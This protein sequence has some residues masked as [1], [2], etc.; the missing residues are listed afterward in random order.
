[1]SVGARILPVATALLLS[2]GLAGRCCAADTHS[3]SPPSGLVRLAAAKFPNLTRCERAIL[4]SA[5]LNTTAHG[6]P[7]PCG[8]SPQFDDPTNDPKNAAQWDRQRDVRAELIRWLFVDPEAVRQVDPRGVAALGARVVGILDLASVHAP[9]G[10]TLQRS[11]IPERVALS[12]ADIGSFALSGSHSGEIFAG[13]IHVRGGVFLDNGFAASAT[14]FFGNSRIDS[15]FNCA[16]GSFNYKRGALLEIFEQEKPALFLGVTRVEGPIWLSAGFKAEGAVDVNGITCTHLVCYGGKFIN[17]GNVALNASGANISGGAILSA[18]DVWNAAELSGLVHFDNARLGGV[19]AATGAKFLGK[20]TEAHGFSA[21]AMTSPGFFW[22]KMELENG[23]T[24]DLRGAVVNGLVDD[25]RSWPQPG[26]LAIDG[27]VYKDFYGGP[28]DAP[29][30]LRWVGLQVGPHPSWLNFS[31]GFH[32][33]PYRQLA[34]VLRE[35]GDEAGAREVLIAEDQALYA[36]GSLPARLWGHFLRLT[37]G[38]G[39]APLRAVVWSLAVVVLGWSVVLIASRAGVMRPTWPETPPAAA[40]SDYE[41]LHPLLYSLDV[42]LPFVNLHQEHY[43]WPKPGASGDCK[44]MGITI[45]CRG[46][47]VRL[48]LWLQIIAGW[49]L[50]AIFLAGVTGLLRND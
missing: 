36:G 44:L 28:A 27:F 17:P 38:Y 41:P 49:L 34:K 30:R 15:D 48:Y 50:S 45:R 18:A 42:F 47:V 9:F 12:G 16:G 33:Q 29:S 20:P 11:A 2:L 24:L 40:D 43:W 37:I 21:I 1:M 31:S 26:R 23:A 3:S 25:E 35:R 10:L 6:D 13:G 14:V 22:Q 46:S 32:P 7:P 19:L 8:P 39:H 4:R 5:D